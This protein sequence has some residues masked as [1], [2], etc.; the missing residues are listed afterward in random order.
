MKKDLK[1]NNNK[2]HFPVRFLK[3][4]ASVKAKIMFKMILPTLGGVTNHVVSIQTYMGLF[5]SQIGLKAVL[6]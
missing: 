2:W 1:L 3:V 5:L 4:L 6:Y